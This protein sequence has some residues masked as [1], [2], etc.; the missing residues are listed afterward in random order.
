[1]NHLVLVGLMGTGKSTIG[2]LAAKELGRKFVDT[3]ALVES[4][5]NRSI[6]EIFDTDGEA[7]FRALELSALESVLSSAEPL[8]VSTGGG[9]IETAACRMALGQCRVAGT[10]VVWLQASVET[11][12]ERTA[13]STNRP[14]LLE[15]D[16]TTS[17]HDVLAQLLTRRES[18]YREVADVIIPTD[19]FAIP[20]IVRDVVGAISSQ[21]SSVASS[22]EGQMRRVHVALG[23]RSYDVVVGRGA[24]EHLSSLLP[25]SAKRAVVVTQE[26]IPALGTLPLPSI[27]IEI[28]AGEEQKTLGTIENLCRQFAQFGLTRN[29]VVIAI[30]GGMVTDVAGFAAASYHRGT[31]VVHVATSLLAMVD[32]AIGGKTGVNLPEGKNLVGAFWQPNG[33]ICDTHFLATLPERELRCG[34]GEVAKYHFIAGDDMLALSSDERIARCVE[35]KANI[36]AEDEREGGKRALLNYGHTF[37]HAIETSTSHRYAHGE[38]VAV[39]LVCAAFLAR[40][41]GRISDQRVDDHIAVLKAYGLS[42]NLPHDVTHEHLVELMARDKKAINGLTFILDGPQGLEVVHDVKADDVLRALNA[43]QVR[44]SSEPA[45]A[46][47]KTEP[48]EMGR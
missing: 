31:A 26:G 30:G 37:G 42:C 1:M 25:S 16:K 43:M 6:K 7:A 44:L 27:T 3:D 38:A 33:V 15:A 13:R 5:S 45:V 28:G 8:V 36:V 24:V 46:E 20:R 41:L 14:L 4:T 22:G 10:R 18:L 11:L 40:H 32:A 35:I 47:S 9:I 17:R 39:G 2:R 29:D 19:G 48:T 21:N 12:V 23:D 34:W